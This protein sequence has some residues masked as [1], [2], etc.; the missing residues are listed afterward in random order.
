M[1]ITPTY[2]RQVVK[3]E[4]SAVLREQENNPAPSQKLSIEEIKKMYDN[5]GIEFYK[6]LENDQI[7][8]PHDR[9]N[10]ERIEF[11]LDKQSKGRD[12]EEL[13]TFLKETE[14]FLEDMMNNGSEKQTQAVLASTK[15]IYDLVK[16]KREENTYK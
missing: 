16:R 4:L 11:E 2:L 13:E 10:V 5:K 6:E 9:Y 14:N 3:E 15:A 7:S 8:D 1:K 12:I